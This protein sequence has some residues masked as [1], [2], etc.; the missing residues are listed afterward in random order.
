M[1]KIL[2]ALILALILTP[3]TSEVCAD[4][5]AINEANAFRSKRVKEA[6]LSVVKIEVS[7]G[8]LE[9]NGTGFIIDDQG[10]VLTNYHVVRDAESIRIQHFYS[11]NKYLSPQDIEVIATD[12]IKDIALLKIKNYSGSEKIAPLKLDKT[13]KVTEDGVFYL[14][15]EVQTDLKSKEYYTVANSRTADNFLTTGIIGAFNSTFNLKLRGSNQDALAAEYN[16]KLIL[17]ENT[18][19][20]GHSGAPIIDYASGKVVAIATG[21]T[22]KQD[23]HA[24]AIPIAFANELIDASESI[25]AS[26][27]MASVAVNS[28]AW[29]A[30]D[31][32]DQYYGESLYA[33]TSNNNT[34]SVKGYVTGNGGRLVDAWVA[35]ADK[36]STYTT[37]TDSDGRYGFKVPKRELSQWKLEIRHP[38]YQPY[39]KDVQISVNK[40]DLKFVVL[41]S[42]NEQVDLQ[43][44]VTPSTVSL[45]DKDSETIRI[46]SKMSKG[47]KIIKEQVKWELC[48]I[49]DVCIDD[50]KTYD[51]WLK[52]S[53]HVGKTD[54]DG[55]QVA[56]S[57]KGS[58]ETQ[59]LDEHEY[60][61]LVFSLK[62]N[63]EKI[64][65]YSKVY[66]YPGEIPETGHYFIK[67]ILKLENGVWPDGEKARV[68]AYLAE[69]NENE[70]I[71]INYPETGTV[72]EDGYFQLTIPAHVMPKDF[73]DKIDI[74]LEVDSGSYRVA[75]AASDANHINHTYNFNWQEIPVLIPM[76]PQ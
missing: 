6:E 22:G 51:T 61:D 2:S 8:D 34:I 60:A 15:N 74:K 66:V 41:S 57:K 56:L 25:N 67:G 36:N 53:K 59:P 17:F 68:S 33:D 71:P 65:K 35:L 11:G 42:V 58:I 54:Q 21:T 76:K 69:N 63:N 20:A 7:I 14:V 16:Y 13:Q 50:Y 29:P 3:H 5:Q 48:E 52:V 27:S 26:E 4:E 44:Y 45:L 37:Y 46:V 38:E 18:I 28:D 49:T 43:F 64:L 24:F 62:D 72:D 23:Y 75:G 73:T 10:S 19:T 12:P 1:H 31:P 39:D 47:S 9:A 55:I 40:R 70:K 32:D 30:I